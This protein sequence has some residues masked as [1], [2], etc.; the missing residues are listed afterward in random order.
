M[1]VR[2]SLGIALLAISNLLPVSGAEVERHAT[3]DGTVAIS[4]A[5]EIVEGDAE[6]L[7]LEIQTAQSANFSISEI[8]LN[9]I[10]GSLYEGTSLARVV[11]AKS[12]NTRVAE[13][14]ICASACFLVF[15]AGLTKTVQNGARVGV[16]AATMESGADTHI[17]IKATESMGRIATLLDV[18]SEIIGR[19]VSTPASQMFWLNEAN[20]ASMGAVVTQGR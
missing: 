15:A 16:H 4:I 13:H 2:V 19:M 12:L 10:G 1:S 6:A 5:G 17:S 9:S 11:R 3:A 7:R 14:S 8:Q 20:L 18:P